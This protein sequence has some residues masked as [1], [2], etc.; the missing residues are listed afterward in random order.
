[1]ATLRIKFL[2]TSVQMQMHLQVFLPDSV[3]DATESG[4]QM[5]LKVLWLLHGEGGDCSD[6]TR[7]SM[8]EHYAQAANIALVMPNLDNS[9]AMNMAHG[10]YPYFRY[11]TDELPHYLRNVVRVLS[12]RPEDNFVAGVSTG[13]YGALRWLLHEPHMFSAGACLSGDVDMVAALRRRQAKG[14]LT[15]DWLAAFGS[16]AHLEDSA[17][18]LFRLAREMANEGAPPPLAYIVWNEAEHGCQDNRQAVQ[19]L[20]QLGLEVVAEEARDCGW[21]LC[22][23]ALREFIEKFVTVEREG[24]Q[25][26]VA[27]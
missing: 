17:D 21:A 24:A 12:D 27:H 7:L 25:P 20:A 19:R 13:G 9:M 23:R 22:D 4:A 26:D 1:L 10:G 3:I 16:A 8:V 2:A 6:W 15:D 5:P 14:T 18:D 11:L